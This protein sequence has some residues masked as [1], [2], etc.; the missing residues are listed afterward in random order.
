MSMSILTAR[1]LTSSVMNAPVEVHEQVEVDPAA[2]VFA[3]QS[4]TTAA[5]SASISLASGSGSV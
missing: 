1:A 3:G 2:F 4:A 5:S